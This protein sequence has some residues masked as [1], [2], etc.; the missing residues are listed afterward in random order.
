[1]LAGSEVVSAVRNSKV[2]SDP[3]VVWLLGEEMLTIDFWRVKRCQDRN[4]S[5]MVETTAWEGS[6]TT[7]EQGKSKQVDHWTPSWQ[8]GKN[9][10]PRIE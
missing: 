9:P 2:Y 5:F 1:V 7:P 6:T 10:A 8:D 4:G 3:M